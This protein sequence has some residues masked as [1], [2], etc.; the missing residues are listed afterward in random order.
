M[1]KTNSFLCFDTEDNSKEL[2]VMGFS[3]FDKAMTQ[4]AGITREGKKFWAGLP[5]T[6]PKAL[7]F[8]D[9]KKWNAWKRNHTREQ[10]K[11][12]REKA[13]RLF[14]WQRYNAPALVKRSKEWL[15]RQ[16]CKYL[17][18]LNTQYDLGNL[19]GD[20]IDV[21][22]CTLVGGRL[23]KA[24]W[25]P[26]VFVDVF[27]I[28]PM[29]VAKLGQAF[30]LEKLET[31]SM[32][33]DKEYV[34]RDTEII[35]RAME[36]AWKY[37]EELGLSHLPPTLGGLCVAV[38]KHWGG[39]NTHDSSEISRAGLYGG[40]VELFKVRNDSKKVCYVDINSLYPYKMLK[41]YPGPL[42]VW[43]KRRLPKFGLL[44]CTI[45]VPKTDLPTL[46]YR[47]KEGRI[48]YPW[49]TIRGTWTIVEIQDAL[50]HG[51]KITRK[52]SCMGTDECTK[53]YAL[54]VT[55]LYEA[56]LQAK[57]PAEKLFFKLLM[58]NLYGRL[59]SSGKIGRTVWQ[60][61]DNHL[62]G[63]PY[64]DKV[65]VN[66]QMPLSEETNWSH[67]AYITAYSRLELL[68]Y[69][70]I[71][72][73]ASMI[74][75]DTDSCIFDCPSGVIPFPI[76]SGLGEMKLESW[77][78][79]CQ[80]FAPK[81]YRVGNKYKAKGVPVRLAKKFIT[82]GEAAFDLPFK[83]REAIRFFDKNNKRKLSVWRE[84]VKTIKANYDKKKLKFNRY[85]PCQV[86][87]S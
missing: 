29:G 22:D 19:F 2:L 66:Y 61:Y 67:A 34:Y 81:M 74:Y 77:E 80:T 41:E 48:L 28:W 44:E 55:R 82:S 16:G 9:Q 12:C 63:I 64:G 83:L 71:I 51:A 31:E 56:R 65:L 69:M 75:C 6:A 73:A 45:Q 53:P 15:Q 27:N 23:I 52:H 40:R 7:I 54:F 20:V 26:Q 60:T 79:F 38:W 87:W 14:D 49:G 35:R 68:R 59:G 78:S 8:A 76:G 32:S 42:E 58:N 70:R 25:G 85:F 84:V 5:P 72:G 17:Y 11:R 3:G 24:I 33:E 37:V 4:F 47:D 21:L 50:A 10:I 46:P 57:S 13:K 1:S 86:K 62:E 18:A 36:F 39:V 30:G 43:I